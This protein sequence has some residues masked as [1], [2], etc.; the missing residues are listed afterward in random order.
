MYL[1]LCVDILCIYMYTCIQ[2]YILSTF[3]HVH[4]YMCIYV[5]T[6]YTCV[7]ED[8]YV[9]VHICMYLFMCFLNPGPVAFVQLHC[10]QVPDLWPIYRRA[11][12]KFKRH[13]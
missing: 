2:M 7:Y 9:Y 6:V 12:Y 11:G 3:T 5:Y 4:M 13:L 10:R 1:C 8:V